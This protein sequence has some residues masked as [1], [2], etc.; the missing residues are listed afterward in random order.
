MTL[1][2]GTI[3]GLLENADLTLDGQFATHLRQLERRLLG[4]GMDADDFDTLIT[5]AR[6]VANE[7]RSR[8]MLSSV[9]FRPRPP[10]QI[11]YRAACV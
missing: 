10:L 8:C 11:Q 2:P 9:T 3:E 1:E 5:E 6:I 4:H 7:E